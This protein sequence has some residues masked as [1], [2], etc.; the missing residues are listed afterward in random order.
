LRAGGTEPEAVGGRRDAVSAFCVGILVGLGVAA[1]DR[2]RTRRAASPHDGPIAVTGGWLE[3]GKAAVLAFGRDRLSAAAGA[4]TFFA[5]LA[6]FPA[7]SAF[8]SLYG[9]V[10]NVGDVQRHLASLRGF[11][12]GGAIQVVGDELSRL[13]A[14]NHGALGVAFGISLAIS[15]WSASSGV[16]ALMD[17]LNVAYETRERRGFI[18]L[19]LEALA[20]TIGAIVM[21]AGVVAL[22]VYT[23]LALANVF[24]A[25]AAALGWIRA[26][27]AIAAILLA[28]AWIYAFA[29]CRPLERWR[30]ITPGSVW[31]TVG[32]MLLSVLFSWYVAHFGSYDRTYGSLGAVVGFLTWIWLSLM[33]LMLGAEL[34][35]EL[36]KRALI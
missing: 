30:W 24:H 13:T 26:P 31:A 5:L 29:P 9:L 2:L 16:K 6:L 8:V 11:L 4:V 23:P 34:N 36:E 33:V 25:P 14:A 15:L 28:T 27:L 10:A 19:N 3:A 17:G 22:E 1:A 21:V 35:N 12:P 20:L 18:R 32:W 7:I